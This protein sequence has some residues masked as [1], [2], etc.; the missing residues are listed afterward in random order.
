MQGRLAMKAKT[1]AAIKAAYE[2]FNP[3]LEEKCLLL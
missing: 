3:S 1:E 2:N